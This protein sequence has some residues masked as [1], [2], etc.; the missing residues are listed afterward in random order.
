MSANFSHMTFRSRCAATVATYSDSRLHVIAARTMLLPFI[1][2]KYDGSTSSGL[3][4][5][6]STCSHSPL[7]CNN[8]SSCV[9]HIKSLDPSNFAVVTLPVSMVTMF[10]CVRPPILTSALDVNTLALRNATEDQRYKQ[11]INPFLGP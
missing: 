5:F 1:N 9:A 6:P 11:F 2:S 3:R 10:S 7:A 4:K 8:A